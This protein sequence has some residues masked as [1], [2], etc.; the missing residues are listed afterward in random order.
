MGGH[1]WSWR[2][3]WAMVGDAP[4]RRLGLITAASGRGNFK[5]LGL[6]LPPKSGPSSYG[7][8]VVE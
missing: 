6:G 7:S 3:D 8:P 2:F 4:G 5:L 1:N